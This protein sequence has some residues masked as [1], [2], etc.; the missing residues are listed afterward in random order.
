MLEISETRD[1]LKPY[2]AT[3]DA[4]FSK[5]NCYTTPKCNKILMNGSAHLFPNPSET[6]C[7]V[8]EYLQEDGLLVLIQRSTYCTLP[9][10]KALKE[11]Y[12][13]IPVEEFKE[14]LDRAGFKVTMTVE[15]GTTKMTK[16]DWYD[17]LRGRVFTTLGEFS[18]EDIEKGI[19]ELNQSWFPDKGENDVIEIRD[20]IV[21]FTATKQ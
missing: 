19:R 21:I 9:M 5:H 14:Y 15:V 7:K 17:K 16:D 6:F 2:L 8:L 10:W 11:I 13:P 20:R 1:G 3:A 4:F 18:D 12:A